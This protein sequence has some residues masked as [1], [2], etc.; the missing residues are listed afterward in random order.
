MDAALALVEPV[1]VVVAISATLGLVLGW[2]HGRL[3]AS[4]DPAVDRI[5]ALLPQSQCAQ[6]GHP[7]CRP[8]AEAIAAGDAIN[9]CPPGGDALVRELAELLGRDATALDPAFGNEQPRRVALIREPDCIGCARCLAVCPVDAIVGAH[10]FLHTVIAQECTGCELCVAPCPV[11]CIEMHSV[12]TFA[13]KPSRPEQS[14]A[15]INCGDCVP[16]CPVGLMPQTLYRLAAEPAKAESWRLEA[17]IE[18]EACERVCPS[19][20]PLVSHFQRA[21]AELHAERERHGRAKRAKRRYAER[22]TRLERDER[23]RQDRRRKRL[24]ALRADS[25]S[26]GR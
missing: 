10:P 16:A 4:P 21:K 1:A 9:K 11:D 14:L 19:R 26:A 12:E 2:A 13:P 18:C 5:D 7:G 6:C 3:G 22:C 25:G 20:I 24:D 17:C 23:A 8:Y 15:C